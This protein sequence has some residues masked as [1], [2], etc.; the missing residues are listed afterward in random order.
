MYK[1]ILTFTKSQASAFIGGMVDYGLMVFT[2]EMF[3]IHYLIGIVIGGV[4]GALVN[5]TLNKLWAFKE[6]DLKYTNSLKNQLFKFTITVLNSI[7]LK[8]MGTYI[9]TSRLGLDY[10]ISKLVV[11]LVVSVLFNYTLQKEWV[12][13]KENIR[14][15]KLNK[16]K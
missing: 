12:F 10:K 15:Q 7:M 16:M 14:S 11:D 6:K 8:S 2:T 9:L 4:I 13:R 3:H 5:F 1:G